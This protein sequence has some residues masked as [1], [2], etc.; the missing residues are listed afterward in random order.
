MQET[1][2]WKKCGTDSHWCDL[3]SLVLDKISDVGVYII[4][5]TGL[6]PRVVRIGQG[7]IADRLSQ[8]RNN[9]KITAYGDLCVTWASVNSQFHR[10]G[11]ERYLANQWKP[12]V[13]DAFP[14]VAPISVNSPFN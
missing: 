12:L 11:I 4:W 13:G 3:S 6:N 1:L 9:P 8:H 5:H 14:N 2:H 7:N 10:D